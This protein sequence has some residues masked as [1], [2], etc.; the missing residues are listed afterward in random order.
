MREREQI[1]ELLN[2]DLNAAKDQIRKK[3]NCH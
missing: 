2:R 1:E 3:E